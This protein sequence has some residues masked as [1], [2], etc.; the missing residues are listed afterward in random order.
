M[1]GMGWRN[2]GAFEHKSHRDFGLK[3]SPQF[4]ECIG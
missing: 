3:S 4:I 2:V 1:K